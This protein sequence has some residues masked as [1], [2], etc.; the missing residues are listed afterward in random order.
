MAVLVSWSRC[1]P[2]VTVLRSEE[3]IS[4][5]TCGAVRAMETQESEF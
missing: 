2:R 1:S 5:D 3:H 4:V